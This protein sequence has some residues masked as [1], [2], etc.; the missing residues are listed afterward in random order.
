MILLIQ[1]KKKRSL[2]RVIRR[3][4]PQLHPLSLRSVSTT[5]SCVR[6]M[7]QQGSVSPTSSG[8][9]RTALSHAISAPVKASQNEIG[10]TM[11]F[12]FLSCQFLLTLVSILK[13]RFICNFLYW[14]F[15]PPCDSYQIEV[16][17]KTSCQVYYAHCLKKTKIRKIPDNEICH[18]HFQNCKKTYIFVDIYY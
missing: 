8:C 18:Y 15:M 6:L 9:K 11:Y 5:T 12:C 13:G 7:L 16:F 10:K 3:M 4:H 2:L 1:T 17:T 14:T